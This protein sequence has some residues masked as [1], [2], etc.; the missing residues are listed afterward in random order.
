MVKS[1]NKP[2]EVPLSYR[3]DESIFLR[4]TEEAEICQIFNSIKDC[5]STDIDGIQNKPVKYVINLIA[6]CLANIFNLVLEAGCFPGAR[7]IAKVSVIVK[8]GDKNEMSNYRPIPI[9]SVFSRG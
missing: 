7:K 9:L 8:G 1:N 4:L 3:C 2:C 6:P 5:S